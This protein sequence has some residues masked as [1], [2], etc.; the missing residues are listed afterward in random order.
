MYEVALLVDGDPEK[1]PLRKPYFATTDLWDSLSN[2]ADDSPI[3][4]GPHVTQLKLKANARI[5]APQ[6]P[7][8]CIYRVSKGAVALQD[9]R[10][11]MVHRYHSPLFFL[12]KVS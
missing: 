5:L 11:R 8:E 6:A 10:G 1:D 9:E 12:Y 3:W 4:S 2:S 7:C